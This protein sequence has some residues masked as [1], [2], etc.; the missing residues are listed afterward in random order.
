MLLVRMCEHE[1]VG[2]C[3]RGHAGVSADWSMLP[4]LGRGQFGAGVEQLGWVL[5]V[6]TGLWVSAG[7]ASV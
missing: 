4:G 5:L 1:G 3:G 6:R 7:R 2:R